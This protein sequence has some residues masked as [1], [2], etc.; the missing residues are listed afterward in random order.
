LGLLAV[1]SAYVYVLFKI[2]T[3]AVVSESRNCFTVSQ[4]RNLYLSNYV[5]SRILKNLFVSMNKV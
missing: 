1:L 5:F 4:S 3:Q 2:S